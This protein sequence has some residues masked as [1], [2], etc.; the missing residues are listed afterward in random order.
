ME[1]SYIA[2]SAK[3]RIFLILRSAAGEDVHKVDEEIEDFAIFQT[4]ENEK[5]ISTWNFRRGMYGIFLQ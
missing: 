5:R 3:R 2:L 4:Q 1:I